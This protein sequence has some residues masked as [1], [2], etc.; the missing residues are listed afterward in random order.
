MTDLLGAAGDFLFGSEE[1]QQSIEQSRQQRGTLG[2]IGNILQSTPDVLGGAAKAAVGFGGIG[3]AAQWVGNVT[4][5]DPFTGRKLSVAERGLGVA[6]LFGFMSAGKALSHLQGQHVLHSGFTGLRNTDWELQRDLKGMERLRPQVGPD[7]VSNLRI[8]GDRI[9]PDPAL[10]PDSDLRHFNV[11]VE[12]GVATWGYMRHAD[13]MR[14]LRTSP[15]PDTAWARLGSIVSHD[16]DDP[17]SLNRSVAFTRG[18]GERY[19]TESFLHADLNG[20]KMLQG[21]DAEKAAAHITAYE[22]SRWNAAIE[23]GLLNGKQFKKAKGLWE[24]L[25]NGE[26]L[27]STETA[28]LSDAMVNFANSV[29]WVDHPELTTSPMASLRGINIDSGEAEYDVVYKQFD[30]IPRDQMTIKEAQQRINALFQPN[31]AAMVPMMTQN[32][33]D[34]YRRFVTEDTVR[35]MRTWYPEARRQTAAVASEIG[36]E[37]DRFS[38]IVGITSAGRS[39]TQNVPFAKRLIETYRSGV[40]DPHE[41]GEILRKGDSVSDADV[42]KA[43][44]AIEAEDPWS[45]MYE[46]GPDTAMK[47]TTFAQAVAKS[48]EEELLTQQMYMARL[49]SGTLFDHDMDTNE[50]FRALRNRA[51]VVVDR[52]AYKVPLGFSLLPDSSLSNPGMYDAMAQAYRNAALELGVIPG[53][54]RALLPDELQ[55]IAWT[56]YRFLGNMREAANELPE[57]MNM[58]TQLA[59]PQRPWPEYYSKPISAM[60]SPA[61]IAGWEMGHGPTLMWNDNVWNM[62]TGQVDVLPF[63][64]IDAVDWSMDYAALR[65]SVDNLNVGIVSTRRARGNY[66]DVRM[67]VRSDGSTFIVGDERPHL[68]EGALRARYPLIGKVDLET[69]PEQVW[70]QVDAVP[71]RNARALYDQLNASTRE[72]TNPMVESATGARLYTDGAPDVWKRPGHHLAINTTAHTDADPQRGAHVHQQVLAE[73]RNAGIRVDLE[74]PRPHHGLT[75]PPL[76][77]S[78]QPEWPPDEVMQSGIFS[79]E[80]PEDMR[81]AWRYLMDLEDGAQRS[82]RIYDEIVLDATFYTDSSRMLPDGMTPII[83]HHFRDASGVELVNLNVGGDQYLSNSTVVYMPDEF[84]EFVKPNRTYGLDP[85]TPFHTVDEWVD[86]DQTVPVRSTGNNTRGPFSQ[87]EA[88][89]PE[90][91]NWKKVTSIGIDLTGAMPRIGFNNEDMPIL[92]SRSKEMTKA[93]KE[94]VTVTMVRL[95]PDADGNVNQLDAT[96]ATEL[97]R[98]IGV[99]GEIRYGLQEDKGYVTR[100][101]LRERHLDF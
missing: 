19:L 26:E 55:A 38:V 36:M 56:Q 77:E 44:R 93:S 61:G 32:I 94:F 50:V 62:I 57:G 49:V 28:A 40:T 96:R 42:S 48:T 5:R 1:E 82:K 4:G 37:A 46:G 53:L 74:T 89:D 12:D 69:G 59:R 83:E 7:H 39:W 98:R 101:A 51:P 45:V 92:V 30:A 100:E 86:I 31:P 52:Q 97:L 43:V 14:F 58:P 35:Y 76:D 25:R 63:S 27:N 65:S 64:G 9:L 70:A 67:H 85:S 88:Q 99:Q 20:T 90:S 95:Q 29:W 80:D 87:Y 18:V 17:F 23:Q 10:R 73:L 34:F 60:A 24:R 91:G 33:A 81:A 68:R 78:G 8:R 72:V 75:R 13:S 71:V 3:D 21:L 16:T 47:T 66:R 2:T 11:D 41:L 6:A 22:F 79:F 84:A 15:D 54:D